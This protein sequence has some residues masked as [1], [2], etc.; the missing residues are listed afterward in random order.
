MLGWLRDSLCG[1]AK[2]MTVEERRADRK[3]RVRVGVTY[4]AAFYIFGGSA[5]LIGLALAEVLDKDNFDKVREIFTMVLPIATGIVTYWFAT[6]QQ[7]NT[8]E[9][10]GTDGN[11]DEAAKRK[12]EEEESPTTP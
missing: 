2:T 8:E 6:R 5:V 7:G 1:N 4:W 10:S 11:G 12:S 3:S 9:P